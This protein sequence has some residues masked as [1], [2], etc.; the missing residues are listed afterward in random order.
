MRRSKPSS[1]PLVC[2]EFFEHNGYSLM[3]NS[4]RE[5]YPRICS[6]VGLDCESCTSGSAR[7]LAAICKGLRGKAIGQLFVQIHPHA[8]CSRMHAHF[9]QSYFAASGAEAAA[10]RKGAMPERLVRV[11]AVA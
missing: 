11:A 7:E 5:D 2:R 4:G 3:E 10:P 6:E 1:K 9:A 8:A